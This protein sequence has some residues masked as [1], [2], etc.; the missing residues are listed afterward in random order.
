M[1]LERDPSQGTGLSVIFMDIDDFRVINDL[2][3][4]TAETA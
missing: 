1:Y 3:G 2:L 4:H